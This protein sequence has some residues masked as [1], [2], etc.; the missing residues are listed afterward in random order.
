MCLVLHV[1]VTGSTC[2]CRYATVRLSVCECVHV[3][4]CASRQC[5]SSSIDRAP[6]PP[7]P[8]PS[9]PS[10]SGA[11]CPSRLSFRCFPRDAVGLGA[12]RRRRSGGGTEAKG[13]LCL[14]PLPAARTHARTRRAGQHPRAATAFWVTSALS[15]ARSESRTSAR[16]APGRSGDGDERGRG[17]GGESVACGFEGGR[18][19]WCGFF[20]IPANS[21]GFVWILVGSCHAMEMMAMMVIVMIFM[22]RDDAWQELVPK[23]TNNNNHDHNRTIQIQYKPP[24]FAPQA[25]EI[26]QK[27]SDNKKKEYS[28]RRLTYQSRRI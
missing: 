4:L 24:Y 15:S 10:F 19:D 28:K 6:S 21:C 20:W 8:T 23:A 2:E 13:R 5:A 12:G 9:P 25:N 1:C 14:A 26:Q 3:C 27:R 22:V 18:A 7:L 17:F 16:G 11:R